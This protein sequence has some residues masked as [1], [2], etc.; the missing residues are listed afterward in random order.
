M[1]NIEVK[2]KLSREEA[3]EQVKRFFGKGG[4]G[5]SLSDEAEGCLSFEG[6]GGYVTA[7]VSAEGTG[8]KIDFVTQ[9]WDFQVKEFASRHGK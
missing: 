9:E 5:L 2:T 1:L 3:T 4:Y 7:Q 8:S 6:S